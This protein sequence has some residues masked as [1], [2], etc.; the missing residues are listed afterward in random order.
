MNVDDSPENLDAKATEDLVASY[1][2]CDSARRIGFRDGFVGESARAASDFMDQQNAYFDG[3]RHGRDHRAKVDR[4]CI[5]EGVGID[6]IMKKSF[7]FYY[8]THYESGKS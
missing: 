5:A 2:D 3:F 8:S 1:V 6:E 4:A 7:D